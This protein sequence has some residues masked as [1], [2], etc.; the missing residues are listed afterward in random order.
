M[1][2]RRRPVLTAS[3]GSQGR[4]APIGSLISADR[5]SRPSQAASELTLVS[6]AI[7][8]NQP[9]ANVRFAASH[10]PV[11]EH[12]DAVSYVVAELARK[13][14]LNSHR[15]RRAANTS[16]TTAFECSVPNEIG[17]DPKQEK[18]TERHVELSFATQTS[19]VSA[20]PVDA[21]PQTFL[22]T[23]EASEGTVL[24][25]PTSNRC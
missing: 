18:K 14:E 9:L 5:S 23:P 19:S 6:A 21:G 11:S 10:Q 17:G 13:D 22:R 3:S 4:P 1:P 20:T 2:V 24:T 7:G 15:S 8:Q 16:R 12:A 25:I